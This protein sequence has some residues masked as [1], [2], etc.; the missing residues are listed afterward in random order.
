MLNI[1]PNIFDYVSMGANG[2]DLYL[3]DTLGAVSFDSTLLVKKQL[4][5]SADTQKQTQPFKGFHN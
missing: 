3:T 4:N 2:V 1:F 5:I